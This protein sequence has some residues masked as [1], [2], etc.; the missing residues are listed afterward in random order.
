MIR[1]FCIC[2]ILSIAFLFSAS[3]SKIDSLNIF[4]Q[5]NTFDSN[6]VNAYCQLAELYYKVSP[7]SSL[8]LAN[9]GYKLA[10]IINFKKGEGN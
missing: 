2:I 7:D 1:H 10:H 4:I 6:Q 3:A 8:I 9:L 5:R